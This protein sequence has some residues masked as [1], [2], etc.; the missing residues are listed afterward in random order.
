MSEQFYII[1]FECPHCREYREEDVPA[2][3][4]TWFLECARCAEP[5]TLILVDGE[6]QMIEK[7]W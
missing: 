6:V 3:A 4:V 7:G 2:H 1:E 5:Y